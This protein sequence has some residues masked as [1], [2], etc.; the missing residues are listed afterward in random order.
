MMDSEDIKEEPGGDSVG[1]GMWAQG[2]EGYRMTLSVEL[3]GSC[4]LY[5]AGEHWRRGRLGRNDVEVLLGW[6]REAVWG[7]KG[8]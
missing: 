3:V 8:R 4:C 2:R 6:V 1:A 5:Q 7:L